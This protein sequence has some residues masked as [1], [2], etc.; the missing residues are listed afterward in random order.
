VAACTNSIC[1]TASPTATITTID[2]AGQVGYGTSIAIGTNGNP[3]ISYLDGTNGD[4]KVAACTNSNCTTA[5]TT[6]IDSNS[7][8]GY[9]TAIAIGTNGNPIISY[10]DDLN[11]QLKVANAWWLA[12]GN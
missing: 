4:L 6:A 12:G 11:F 5:Y 2:S 10:R 3:I 9:D 8:V 7:R 1:A